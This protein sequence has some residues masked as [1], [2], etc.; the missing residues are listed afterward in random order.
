MLFTTLAI[1]CGA[2]KQFKIKTGLQIYQTRM[3]C[4]RCQS[5]ILD[6]YKMQ[7]THPPM[8][9]FYFFNSF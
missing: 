8:S 5:A 9:K 4:G 2:Y 6:W 7:E 3:I 1:F